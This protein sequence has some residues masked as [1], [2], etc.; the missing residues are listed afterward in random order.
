MKT[1][2][3]RCGEKIVIAPVDSSRSRCG[4]CNQAIKRHEVVPRN[5]KPIQEE[6]DWDAVSEVTESPAIVRSAT[7]KKE[8]QRRTEIDEDLYEPSGFEYEPEEIEQVSMSREWILF[9]PIPD[10][11]LDASLKALQLGHLIDPIGPD[12]CNILLSSY[13]HRTS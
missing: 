5:P 13:I 2:K 12:D 3:V 9:Q 6:Q 10:K 7:R 4:P 1:M 11:R 8:D